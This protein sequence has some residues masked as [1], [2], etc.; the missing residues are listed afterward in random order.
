MANEYALELIRHAPRDRPQPAAGLAFIALAAADLCRAGCLLAAAAGVAVWRR[1]GSPPRRHAAP[2]RLSRRG[3]HD[4]HAA[5]QRFGIGAVRAIPFSMALLLAWCMASAM[6]APETD[7]VLRRA[8]LEVVVVVSLMLSV[9]TIGAGARL[10]HLALAAGGVLLVNF[11][12]I[13]LIAGGA[14]WRRR[15]RSGAGGQLARALRPQEY[16]RRG[17]R[18]HRDLV[19]VHPQRPAQLDRHRHRRWRPASSWP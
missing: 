10:H 12:S 16:R 17:L 1:A 6:W 8:G 2:G 4:R 19:P 9:E 11:L 3:R 15:D 14:P 18:H 7:I 13:P 5:L